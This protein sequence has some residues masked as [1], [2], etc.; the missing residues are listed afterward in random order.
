MKI[1][2]L[3]T[4][5]AVIFSIN[6]IAATAP[7]SATSTTTPE[8]V[9]VPLSKKIAITYFGQVSSTSIGSPS[10]FIPDNFNAKGPDTIN[11]YS[12]LAVGYKFQDDL[13]LKLA[14]RFEYRPIG[15]T[16]ATGM[17]RNP[18][19]S[20]GMDLH[21]LNHRI[22]LEKANLINNHG[23]NTKATAGFELP[24]ETKSREISGMIISPRVTLS[25]NYTLPGSRWSFGLNLVLQEYFYTDNKS[26]PD[27]EPYMDPNV[28]YKI[29]EKLSATAEWEGYGQHTRN[30]AT[31][32][33]HQDGTDFH[34][35]V[36]Y[37]ITPDLSVN[38]YLQL[39]PG[40]RINMD[41]SS[42]GMYIIGTLM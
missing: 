18:T 15:T 40:G 7:T 30:A 1:K 16:A 35:G 5:T 33:W 37:D 10:R 3:L 13:A 20:N 21:L 36:A 9:G 26:Q 42:F 2:N 25:N 27:W 6:A 12:S 22:F 34:I 29:T 11:L 19:N 32:D 24:T 23:F 8:A 4:A 17:G 14:N 28:S 41:T 38:P 31:T 39:L